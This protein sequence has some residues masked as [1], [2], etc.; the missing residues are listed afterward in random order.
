MMRYIQRGV[1]LA[2]SLVLPIISQHSVADADVTFHGALVESVP[3]DISGGETIVAD[4]G[5]SLQTTRLIESS[6][7][8]TTGLQLL[9]KRQ[10][11]IAPLITCAESSNSIRLKVKGDAASFNSN[12]LAGDR[13]GVGFLFGTNGKDMLPV[14]QWGVASSS[15]T[16]QTAPMIPILMIRQDNYVPE[17]GPFD[18]MA[19]LIAN[20]Q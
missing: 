7:A 19:S 1:V 14:N 3:C 8:P 17:A 18:V 13:E 2:A 10:V 4:F 15:N 12:A 11:V 5:D 9:Q 6:A 16:H 20:Y